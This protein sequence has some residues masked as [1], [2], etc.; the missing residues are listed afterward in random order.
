M[1]KVDIASVSKDDAGDLWLTYYT[2]NIRHL[3]KMD[4]VAK[5]HTEWVSAI[6]ANAEVAEL[7]A[8]LLEA[9]YVAREAIDLAVN[10][11][12]KTQSD[13]YLVETRLKEALTKLEE[14]RLP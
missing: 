10:W 3:A 1:S 8:D 7:N 4:D 2:D 14:L 6:K 9:L 5:L 11:G 12:P 13:E